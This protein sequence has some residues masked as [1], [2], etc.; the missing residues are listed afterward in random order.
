[1]NILAWLAR[2]QDF[3]TEHQN[4]QL[5]AQYR[6]SEVPEKDEHK[7]LEYKRLVTG[8]EAVLAICSVIDRLVE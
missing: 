8:S 2:C 5:I 4:D 6:Y 7:A 1:M 3:I